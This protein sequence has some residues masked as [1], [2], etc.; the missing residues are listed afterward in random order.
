MDIRAELIGRIIAVG[1]SGFWIFFAVASELAQPDPW[2]RK[3]QVILIAIFVF[4]VGTITAFFNRYAG[5]AILT[6]EGCIA[7]VLILTRYIHAS[8]TNQILLTLVLALPPIVAGI[9]MFLPVKQR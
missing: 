4:S 7:L 1:W 5:G 6:I 9:M 8:V 3:L 2:L